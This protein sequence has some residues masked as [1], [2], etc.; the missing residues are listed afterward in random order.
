[1]NSVEISTQK[2]EMD[3]VE[4]ERNINLERLLALE[5]WIAT[6]QEL[7]KYHSLRVFGGNRV[8]SWMMKEDRKKSKIPV[9]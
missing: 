4:S 3:K 7:P 9:L 2:I 6:G 8:V 5:N 1:M